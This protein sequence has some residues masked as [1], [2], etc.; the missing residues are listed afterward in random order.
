ML[1][2]M[3]YFQAVI[4]HNSFSEAAEECHISQSAISQQ[5]QALERELGVALLIRK[6]R[7][8]ELTAAGEYFYR[9]SLI[10][11]AD[12]ERLCAETRRIAQGD[13]EKLT[14]GFLRSYVGL[15]LSKAIEQFMDKYPDV[16][17]QIVHGN[18]EELYYLLR[19]ESVD[20][21]FNDQRRAFSDE[22]ENQLLTKAGC[23]I[24]ISA[25]ST[26][27]GWD[28]I[29]PAE[30]KNTPCILIASPKQHQAEWAYYHDVMGFHGEYLF[31]ENL[32]EARLMVISG[33]GFMP[34]EGS[35][36]ESD[37]D[38]AIKQIPLYRGGN[39]ITKNYCVFWKAAHANRYILGFAEILKSQFDKATANE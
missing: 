5:I 6:N 32:A 13:E 29:S 37:F 17:V 20:L 21:V 14:I 28:K 12:Y 27:A 18:H 16:S 31:A 36:E 34:I 1:R 7:K 38:T 2:Q 35:G 8:F 24:G 10:L 25:R 19:T 4:E 33:Q 22:Y 23:S 30:L 3:K 9:K 26:L 15:A 11:L 39:R